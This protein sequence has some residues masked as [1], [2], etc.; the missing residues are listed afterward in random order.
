MLA[1]VLAVVGHIAAHGV[2]EMFDGHATPFWGLWAAGF[3]A[4]TVVFYSLYRNPLAELVP[5]ASRWLVFAKEAVPWVLGAV[6]GVPTFGLAVALQGIG[7]SEGANWG[8]AAAYAVSLL[9]LGFLLYQR[10]GEFLAVH[11]RDLRQED[12]THGARHRRSH[13][14]WLLSTVNDDLK[15][16]QGLPKCLPAGVAD[17]TRSL[18]DEWEALKNA[19]ARWNWEMLT[20]GIRPHT[21][22]GERTVLTLV[23]SVES[24]LQAGWAAAIL[25]RYREFAKLDVRVWAI[26]MDPSRGRRFVMAAATDPDLSNPKK[27]IGVQFNKVDDLSVALTELLRHIRTIDGV[28]A[29]RITID[30]TGG[31]KPASLVAGAVTFRSESKTQYVDTGGKKPVFEYD[32]VIDPEPR[33]A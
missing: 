16:T 10:R 15:P 23:C 21:K 19:E 12:I 22:S 5:G 7:T 30:F 2:V 13:I 4:L 20:R 8:Q 17:G 33:G 28:P 31:Q 18:D 25:R 24:L 9:F 11:T 27:C 1:F 6:A 32:V 26:A 29:E 3:L 14:V